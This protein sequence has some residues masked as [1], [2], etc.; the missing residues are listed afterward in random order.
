MCD[1]ECSDE[2]D[3]L[4]TEFSSSDEDDEHKSVLVGEGD[5]LN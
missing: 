1:G 5:G 2:E 3:F 4:G